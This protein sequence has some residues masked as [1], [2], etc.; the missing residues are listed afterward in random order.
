MTVDAV[1][2]THSNTLETCK[3]NITVANGHYLTI[4]LFIYLSIYLLH[5]QQH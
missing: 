3:D 5:Y 1:I 4:Y 2:M